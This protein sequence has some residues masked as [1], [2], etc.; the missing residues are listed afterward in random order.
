MT[1]RFSSRLTNSKNIRDLI[2]NT[3]VSFAPTKQPHSIMLMK[4]FSCDTCHECRN[5][6]YCSK[7]CQMENW[8]EHN[9]ICRS[10]VVG[11]SGSLQVKHSEQT[12]RAAATNAYNQ[13]MRLE[14]NEN[15][16]FT[17]FSKLFQESKPGG[18]KTAAREMKQIALRQEQHER[19]LWLFSI[20]NEL[21]H[22]DVDRLT[23]SNSPLLVLLECRDPTA[24]LGGIRHPMLLNWLAQVMHPDG[25]RT[26]YANQIL[27]ARQ[28]V[29]YGVDVNA[30]V[31]PNGT[32]PLHTACCSAGVTNLDF[33]NF[34]LQS[35]ADPNARNHKGATPL[36]GTTEWAPSAAKLLIEWPATDV[37]IVDQQGLSIFTFVR[38][39]IENISSAVDGP[40]NA[41]RKAEDQFRLQQWLEVEEM[42]V[43]KGAR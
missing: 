1:A 22:F 25:H 26:S 31:M 38:K 5:V 40:G 14:F 34:L 29:D 18:R 28:L 6:L 33:I 24:L 7:V 39:V 36:M 2:L 30:A 17:Q 43:K 37:N 3:V 4:C 10:L 11:P 9:K 15:E 21:V 32:T 12:A 27:L 41:C 20:L 16:D 8:K 42:L 23:W 13:C 19:D 35:G